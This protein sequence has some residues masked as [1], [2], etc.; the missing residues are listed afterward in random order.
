MESK[1]HTLYPSVAFGYVQ[2][3]REF[4][5]RFVSEKKIQSLFFFFTRHRHLSRPQADR[6][7][8]SV[9]LSHWS[10]QG[11]S[12]TLEGRAESLFL[13]LCLSVSLSPFLAASNPSL[14]VYTGTPLPGPDR[15]LRRV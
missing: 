7:C 1:I 2:Y 9:C 3:M 11:R 14:T 13:S 4:V 8:L 10:P 15:V 6:V 12:L 5:L